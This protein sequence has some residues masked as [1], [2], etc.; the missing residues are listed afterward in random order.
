MSTARKRAT[1]EDVLS[2]PADKVAELVD[3]ELHV[4]PRPA[5]L[6]ANA[7]TTLGAELLLP[8][9]KGRGGPGG[10]LFLDEPE[11]HLGAHVLVSDLAAWRRERM[12]ELPD[13]P[14]I[15]TA[16]DWLC[17]VLSPSTE[18]LD[19]GGKLPIYARQGV[20]YAWLVNPNTRVLEVFRLDGSTY[21]L[22][23]THRDAELVR[24]EP[25]E[26]HELE[27]ALLWAR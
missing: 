26:A 22:I 13:A 25:F 21:R 4:S 19:R 6:H 24:A 18:A 9:G 11:L 16:P 5:T 17:E 20:A 12:P 27:L 3:G 7:A 2:A 1:Y 15:G 10:W 14:F 8:F 23:A